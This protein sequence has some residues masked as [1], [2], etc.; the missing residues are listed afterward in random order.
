MGG[1]ERVFGN[2]KIIIKFG[3]FLPVS[4]I[5]NESLRNISCK[6]CPGVTTILTYHFR[7]IARIS[8]KSE[9]SMATVHPATTLLMFCALSKK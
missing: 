7:K 6:I 3:D 8:A 5:S 1:G 2:F 9:T 4:F